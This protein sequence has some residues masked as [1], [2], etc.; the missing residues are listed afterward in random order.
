MTP[1][2]RRCRM[3]NCIRVFSLRHDI[4]S[5][6]IWQVRMDANVRWGELLGETA[7]RTKVKGPGHHTFANGRLNYFERISTTQTNRLHISAFASTWRRCDAFRENI[8]ML[9]C[10]RH[11]PRGVWWLSCKKSVQ[12]KNGKAE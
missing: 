7:G 9:R 5:L 2:A 11:S 6:R 10:Q 8:G 12:K 4:M 1:A 3:H